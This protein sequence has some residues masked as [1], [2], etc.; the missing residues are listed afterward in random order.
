MNDKKLNLDDI[1]V[2]S[3]TDIVYENI[4]EAILNG[5]LARG[6]RLSE[7]ILTDELGVS[8]TPIKRALQILQVEGLVEI[9]PRSG[10][11]VTS[12]FSNMD[13]TIVI[14]A[15]LEGLAARFAAEKADETDIEGLKTQLEIM[16]V[17]TR[18]KKHDKIIEA[19]SEFHLSVHRISRNQY[20]QQLIDV[21]RGFSSQLRV[22]VLADDDELT[23]GLNEH[24]AVFNAIK[25]HNGVLA[26][27]IM[28]GHVLHT[29]DFMQNEPA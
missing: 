24:T 17:L 12:S 18:S 15:Y 13:E 7:R 4:K 14:R 6:S 1:E 5:K 19:N 10:T 11:Y 9:R 16:E 20:M 3:L 23:R 21:L 22:R 29:L 28:R 8:S 27:E 26:E 2:K 25:A